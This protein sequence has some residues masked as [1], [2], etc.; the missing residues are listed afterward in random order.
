MKCPYCNVD[1]NFITLDSR[2]REFGIKRRRKCLS[3]GYNFATIEIYKTTKEAL[4]SLDLSQ[5]FIESRAITRER[6]RNAK[7]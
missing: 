2:S 1:D 7:I 6:K 3:C 4:K 5:K